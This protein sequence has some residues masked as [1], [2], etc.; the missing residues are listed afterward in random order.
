MLERPRFIVARPKQRLSKKERDRLIVP[1]VRSCLLWWLAKAQVHPGPWD[2][3]GI[4]DTQARIAKHGIR[5]VLLGSRASRPHD[6]RS[7]LYVICDKK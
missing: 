2:A 6:N 4:I 5:M 1:R 7:H 3:A